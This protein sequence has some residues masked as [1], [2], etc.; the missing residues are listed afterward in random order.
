MEPAGL[1]RVKV[2]LEED[3][4]PDALRNEYHRVV[5]SAGSDGRLYASS[6]GGQRSS[7][8][9]SFTSANALLCLPVQKEVLKKG[10]MCEA[11]L[12]GQLRP[13]L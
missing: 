2:V 3:V 5:V 8:I 9:G 11:L 4:K 6:T 13:G 12:M 7:R 10:E 1:P